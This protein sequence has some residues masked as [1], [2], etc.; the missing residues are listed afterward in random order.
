VISLAQ[1][2]NLA[3]IAEGVETPAQLEKLR[4]LGCGFAQGFYF[5]RP[6]PAKDAARLMAQPRPDE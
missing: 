5:A 2:L 3:V 4:E 6:V 1:S